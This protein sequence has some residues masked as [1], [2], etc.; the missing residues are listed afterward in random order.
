MQSLT[1]S[2]EELRWIKDD[3]SVTHDA[4]HSTTQHTDN[5]AYNRQTD[6]YPNFIGTRLW[7]WGL[8]N[9]DNST[10]RNEYEMRI[11]FVNM[12][13]PFYATF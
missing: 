7:V 10:I 8:I 11:F 12:V 5:D 4:Q 6:G 9:I 3:H 2:E 1:S 13:F